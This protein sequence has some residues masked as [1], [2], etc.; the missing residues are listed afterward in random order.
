M[1]PTHKLILSDEDKRLHDLDKDPD[2]LQL[3][4]DLDRPVLKKMASSQRYGEIP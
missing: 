3:A 4:K 2:E 1:T